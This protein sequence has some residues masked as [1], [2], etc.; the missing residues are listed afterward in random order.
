MTVQRGYMKIVRDLVK[1]G[2][3]VENITL[4]NNAQKRWE[5]C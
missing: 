4:F 1:D 2:V 5:G 3:A